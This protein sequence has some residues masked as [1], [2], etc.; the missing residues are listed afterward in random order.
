L[1]SGLLAISASCRYWAAIWR[2][3]SLR[4]VIELLRGGSL[5]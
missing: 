5:G 1:I 2:K 4:S 3:K